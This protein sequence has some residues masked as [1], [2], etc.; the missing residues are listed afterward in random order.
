MLNLI[1]SAYFLS[2]KTKGKKVINSQNKGEGFSQLN[3]VNLFPNF[4]II[5]QNSSS[6]AYPIYFIFNIVFL[7][8]LILTFNYQSNGLISGF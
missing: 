7:F 4:R 1:G 5:W 2:K 3:L 8:F 6:N